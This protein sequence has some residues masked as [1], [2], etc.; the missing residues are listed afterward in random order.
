MIMVRD[1]CVM[2]FLLLALPAAAQEEHEISVAPFVDEAP[3]DRAF[4]AYR[5]ALLAAVVARDIDQII[6]MSASDIFL[7][8]HN[9]GEP[10]RTGL[11]AFRKN[12][13]GEDA[14]PLGE[15]ALYGQNAPEIMRAANQAAY[16][17][18][19]E[20]VLRGGG[21][22]GDENKTV[23]LAPLLGDVVIHDQKIS[24]YDQYFI[25]FDKS[26]LY[27]RP[28]VWGN[29]T[30][31]LPYGEAVELIAPAY[32]TRFFEIR[33]ANGETGFVDEK[34]LRPWLGFVARFVCYDGKWLMQSFNWQF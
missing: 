6:A 26:G 25:I 33:R 19:L 8:F 13:T 28:S 2:L 10:G 16:L 11:A 14:A 27:D 20:D 18:A 32:G 9:E 7:E 24:V 17:D 31:R 29:V 5:E 21:K 15:V 3:N 12:L 34:Q 22:F 1:V 30:G 23:F 4:Q